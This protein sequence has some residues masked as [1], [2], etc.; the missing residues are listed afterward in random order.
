M[1][2][3]FPYT[4]T[5][6]TC[7]DCELGEMWESDSDVFKAV[8]EKLLAHNLVK[9]WVQSWASW[10]KFIT[11]K[12]ITFINI[13]ALFSYVSLCHRTGPSFSIN[14][15]PLHVPSILTTLI[16]HPNNGSRRVE[17][18][19][20]HWQGAQLGLTVKTMNYYHTRKFWWFTRIGLITLD[21]VQIWISQNKL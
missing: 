4:T 21:V 17:T 15:S 2:L 10:I 18:I 19:P 3:D 9:K 7:I 1:S 11:S 5:L 20:Y 6:F 12:C 8:L 16:G 14:L 13:L